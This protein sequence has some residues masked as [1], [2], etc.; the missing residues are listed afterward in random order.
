MVATVVAYSGGPIAVR[1]PRDHGRGV[2][3]TGRSMTLEIG[4]AEVLARGGEVAL[5]GIG[6]MVDGR[7]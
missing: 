6:S 2:A 7:A 5:V 4:K 1:Y 3:L